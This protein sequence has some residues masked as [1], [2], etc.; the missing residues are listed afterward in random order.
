MILSAKPLSIVEAAQYVDKEKKESYE[1][2]KTFGKVTL[3]K[4][5]KIR[6]E[7]VKTGNSK[8]REEHIVKVIDL[9]PKDSEEVHKIFMDANLSEEE[10]NTILNIL[11]K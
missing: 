8:I 7:L 4:A 11:Q 9:M 5:E 2:F 10:V 3:S 1:Y 6:E